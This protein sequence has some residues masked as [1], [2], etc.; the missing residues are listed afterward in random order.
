VIGLDGFEPSS[1]EAMIAE[2]GLPNLTSL[3]GRGGMARVGTT[4]PALTPV[5]WSTFATGSNPGGHGIFDFLRRNPQTYL[6]DDGLH[7][8]EQEDPS[9]P[10]KVTNLRRAVPVWERLSAA[11]VRSIVLRCPCTY[12]P[13]RLL[14]AMLSGMGVPD[15]RGGCANSTFFTSDGAVVARRDEHVVRVRVNDDGSVVTHLLPPRHS[16]T[17]A[18]A[19]FEILLSIDSE[20]RRLLVRSCGSPNELEVRQGEWSDW[21]RVN[22]RLGPLVSARGIVRF[23]LIQTEPTL[24]LYASPINLDPEA[25]LCPISSPTDYAGQLARSLGPFHTAGLVEDC[26][27]LLNERLSEEAFLAQ[28]EIA[29]RE[30]AAM[31]VHE[32]GRFDE[33]LFYCLFDTPDRVQH[34]LWRFREPH[35]PANRGRTASPSLG[36]AIEDHYRRGDQIIGEVLSFVDDRTLLVVLSDHGFGSFQRGFH[37]NKW[38]H[39]QGLLALKPGYELGPEESDFLR[40]VD[41]DRTRAYGLGLSGLYLNLRG[42]EARGAVCPDEA[43][44]L[45]TSLARALCKLEDPARGAIAIRSAL[46]REQVYSGPFVDEAP[47]LIINY[48]PGYRISWS[49]TRGAVSAGEHFEDNTRKWSGDHVIDPVLVPGILLMNQP[50]RGQGARLVDLAPTIL[51]ALGVPAPQACEGCTLLL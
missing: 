40:A 44:G 23:H 35:H 16:Q 30:R 47:D 9:L 48:A 32:L 5:A 20:G 13:E 36:R 18:D 46:P 45:K 31:M 51:S 42:R 26:H 25:P 12:P 33:G 2:G 38:L 1:V 6:P 41:W 49:S 8:F 24:E 50:F 43:E 27:G 29:W 17:R 11:D 37:L 3:I 10:P 15:L 14:G 19:R 34:M 22:F 4:Y 7:R 21:L 39:D 28:C